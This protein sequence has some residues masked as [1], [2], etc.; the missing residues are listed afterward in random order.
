MYLLRTN[1]TV[2][3]HNNIYH[4]KAVEIFP[5]KYKIPVST[6][7]HHRHRTAISFY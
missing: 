1:K 6:G 5:R 7:F 2:T 4:H 3:V